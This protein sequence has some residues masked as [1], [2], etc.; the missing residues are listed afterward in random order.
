MDLFVDIT[1]FLAV[2]F[3]R[4]IFAAPIANTKGI[5][6][7]NSERNDEIIFSPSPEWKMLA[8]PN[9]RVFSLTELKVATHNFRNDLVLGDGGFG[10]VYKGW[11]VDRANAETTIIAVKKLGSES[12]QG[13][14]EWQV[15]YKQ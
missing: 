8:E 4:Y 3:S 15:Q 1:G 7:G 12:M 9:M 14:Y 2:H 13:F 5:S 6:G 11:L 10:T